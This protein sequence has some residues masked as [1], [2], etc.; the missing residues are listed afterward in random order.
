L[1]LDISESTVCNVM[2]KAG[3]HHRVAK[4]APYLTKNHKQARIY[5]A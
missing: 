3:Y 5:W 1:G 4:K 2:A